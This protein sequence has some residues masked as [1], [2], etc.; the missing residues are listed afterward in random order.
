L[1]RRFSPHSLP[2]FGEIS[3]FFWKAFAPSGLALMEIR[4]KKFY[5][6]VL[7]F[8]TF[9][10]Y[11]KARWDFNSSRARQII[12]ATETLDNIKSVTPRNAPSCEFHARPLMALSSDQQR[13]AWAKAVEN[14]PDG[15]VTASAFG[16][17]SSGAF[18]LKRKAVF[19]A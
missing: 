5:K 12:S 4:D 16:H 14:A 1:P 8:D 2:T 6:D 10:K 7:G 13:E 3:I 11:C 15:K 19:G 17:V 9:E 18:S